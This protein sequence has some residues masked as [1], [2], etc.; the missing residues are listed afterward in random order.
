MALT[1]SVAF[2]GIMTLYG[3]AIDKKRLYSYIVK[4]GLVVF[5]AIGDGWQMGFMNGV[6]GASSFIADSVFKN[7][8]SGPAN[9]LDGCQ[10]PRFNYADTNSDTKYTSNLGYPRG[11]EYLRVWDT[12]DCKIGRALGFGP[13]VSVPNLFL[14]ILGGFFTGG[15][16][17]VFF[18]A[19]FA[20]AFFMLSITVRAIHIFLLS[21]TSVILLMYVSPIAITAAMFERSKDIFA[22]WRSNLIGFTLQPM[23]LFC[24]LG[25]VVTIF[26]KIV[27]G[28]VTFSASDPAD[29]HGRSSPKAI[30][31]VGD[32]A[33]TSLYCIFRVANIK[34]FDGFE[35]LGIGVPMIASMNSAKL[36]TIIRAGLLMF[37]LMQ[38]LEKIST[39][40]AALVGGDGLSSDWGSAKKMASKSYGALRGIQQRGMG[41]AK[42]HGIPAIRSGV[43]AMKSIGSAALDRGK[44]V[45]RDVDSSKP[46]GDHGGGAARSGAG[47]HAA[48][49]SRAA[50]AAAGSTAKPTTTDHS[51]T[52]AKP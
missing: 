45:G 35:A 26:D 37:I 31:C 18:L 50:S 5:F 48:S 25:I 40:S 6:L 4:I 16:G 22:K 34:T 10:F 28:D 30:N 20:F 11:K 42:K 29:P 17:I 15:L 7:D 32:A 49:T 33:D 23:I 21:T 8:E 13:E 24:Y 38:F 1:L 52:S 14:M 51:G 27:I 19:A 47:D 46:A 3:S 2:F 39:F 43:S 41:L 36:Q 12:L 44:S 9:K